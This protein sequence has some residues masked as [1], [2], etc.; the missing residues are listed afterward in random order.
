MGI[1]R[2]ATGT[3]T[4]VPAYSNNTINELESYADTASTKA[5]EASASAAVAS[6]QA[7]ESATAAFNAQASAQAAEAAYDDFDDRYLGDK[8]SDPTL[9]NDGDP[10]VQGALYFNT[11]TSVLRVYNGST[12]QDATSAQGLTQQE[13][14]ALYEPKLD[15]TTRQKFFRR[16]DAPD[17]VTDG[18]QE[19][20]MW[21]ETDT[22]DVY[23]WREIDT[24]VFS[25][26]LFSTGTDDSDTLDGGS[27]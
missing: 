18:L 1:Y 7:N 4:A 27:Y 8:T 23:F 26:V 12:W 19:G 21:Y 16:D 3:G 14:D 10:L 15:G 6:T 22:E 25:W 11:N 20:D 5:N 9:D 2:G 24:N 17:V 13:A